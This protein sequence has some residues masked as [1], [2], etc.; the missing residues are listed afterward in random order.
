MANLP[1][2]KTTEA[3]SFLHCGNDMF[4]P[5]YIK[6]KRPEL[7]RYGAMF[8]CLASRA[9]HIDVTHQIDMT[10]LSRHFEE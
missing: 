3:P 2:K 9:V 1:Y 6:E 8:V 4:E 5:F 10:H 7:M